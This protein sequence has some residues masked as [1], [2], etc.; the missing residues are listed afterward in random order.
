[1]SAVR[2]NN[3]FVVHGWMINQLGLSGRELQVYAIIYGFSQT[4]GQAFK[5]SLQ[6]LA[7]WMGA[8]KRNT[9]RWVQ[10]LEGK[11]LLE[12]T[13]FYTNG[14]KS[15]QYR[16]RTTCDGVV[17]STTGRCQN[18]NGVLSNRQRGCCQNDNGGV[19]KMTTNNISDKDI[20]I[21]IDREG[22]KPPAPAKE[23]TRF[24]PPTVEEVAAY[25]RE[26]GNRIDA[27]RFVDYYTAAKWMRGKTK[28]KDWKACVRTWERTSGQQSAPQQPTRSRIRT[29]Q[30][31]S[32]GQHASGFGWGE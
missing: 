5:G 32:A 18:D 10:S 12:K 26:R 28:I 24:K 31:H 17:K 30:E 20:D 9:L 11:G 13:D 22:D 25:C 27:Q 7:D 8:T 4:D 19:V 3:Y 21:S 1:M 23:T 6:Y 16:C 29:E 15:C 14:V 2:D